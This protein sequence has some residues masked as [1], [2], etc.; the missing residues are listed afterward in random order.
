[1]NTLT[2][3]RFGMCALVL[4]AVPLWALGQEAAAARQP[5]YSLT[6]LGGFDAAGE[7]YTRVGGINNAGAI[8]GQVL[9]Y[10]EFNAF[11]RDAFIYRR[12][13]MYDI[14]ELPQLEFAEGYSI[15]SRGQVAG[16]GWGGPCSRAFL[17]TDGAMLDLGTLGG[18]C[19]LASGIN[20]RGAVT[21]WSSTPTSLEHAFLD[22]NGVMQ[23]LGSENGGESVGNAINDAGD[24]TGWSSYQYSNGSTEHAFLYRHGAMNDLGTLGGGFSEGLAIN[25]AGQI[26]GDSETS[27]GDGPHAFLY[28]KGVMQDLGPGYGLGINNS[29]QVVGTTDYA[30]GSAFLYSNGVRT[31]LAALISPSDPLAPYVQLFEA[32]GI[33]D[34]GLIVANGYDS[35][36]PAYEVHAYLLTPIASH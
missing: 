14:G 22:Q 13:T 18:D 4:A 32:A 34:R 30:P 3:A 17:Y 1:M 25:S 31:H 33:N 29:G 12:G 27:S 35:R 11:E 36:R 20:A 26:T 5:I 16:A 15:N 21:G 23:D 28:S 8:T 19:A 10:T 6:D 7:N 9:V 24:V 2:K